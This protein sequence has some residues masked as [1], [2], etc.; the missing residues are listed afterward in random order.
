[1][2]TLLYCIKQGLKNFIRNALFSIASV[3]TVSAC[4]FLFGIF[5]IIAANI[6]SILIEAETNVGI[7]VFFEENAGQKEK[8][9]IRNAIEN[10]GGVREIRYVSAD[11][12]WEEFSSSYFGEESDEIREA[13]GS[14]NPLASSDSFEVF[15]NDINEQNGMV[16]MLRNTSNVR[17]V[18][19]AS[20]AV[21]MLNKL[22]D[23]VK[24][25]S[26]I[27]IGILFAVSV[28]LISNTINVSAVFR[29][30]ENEIMKM[31]GAKDFMIR[32]PFVVEGLLIGLLGALIPLF[33]I[34]AGYAK[35]SKWFTEQVRA[36]TTGSTINEVIAL[37]PIGELKPLL[38][39]S[40]LVLGLGMGYFV[41]LFTINRHLRA[42]R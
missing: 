8:D 2:N 28:F 1:L 38:L 25:L 4:I 29:K 16:E 20:N 26:V 11:E 23:A 13:F 12:A 6:Q 19:F 42:M 40:G 31:I 32:A 18:N 14:E 36:L 17:E 37:V 35:F 10:Y 39:L 33:A 30:R 15:M 7:T 41:S 21:S 24:W 3:A 22:N 5:L 27:I 34:N 9:A